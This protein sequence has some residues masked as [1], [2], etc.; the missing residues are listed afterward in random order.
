[1]DV[2]LA[3][4]GVTSILRGTCSHCRSQT[5]ILDNATACCG[6][7][8]DRINIVDVRRITNPPHKANRKGH[9]S[10][11]EQFRILQHQE[12]RCFWCSH[13]FGSIYRHKKARVKTLT[14][15]WDHVIPY[16]YG[17][18][19]RASNL[20]AS[21]RVCNQIKRDRYFD[22]HATCRRFIKQVWEKNGYKVEEEAPVVWKM[23]TLF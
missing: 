10:N 19:S 14:I 22:D 2:Q 6:L 15:E 8:P 1:M 16:V 5:F 23:R 17:Q 3:F 11:E 4:F 20:V 12:Y 13:V 21:C 7:R 9:L 18:D